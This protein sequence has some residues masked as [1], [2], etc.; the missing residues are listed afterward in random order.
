MGQDQLLNMEITPDT[1]ETERPIPAPQAGSAPV[2]FPAPLEAVPD[3]PMD[4]LARCLLPDADRGR[5][6][7]SLRQAPHFAGLPLPRKGDAGRLRLVII[8]EEQYYARQAAQHLCAIEKAAREAQSRESDPDDWVLF[9]ALSSDGDGSPASGPENQMEGA[10]AVVS[11][12]LLDPELDTGDALPGVPPHAAQQKLDLA[13]LKAEGVL[14]RAPRGPALSAAVA[15]QLGSAADSTSFWLCRPARS[16][17][18]WWRSFASATASRCAGWA[19]PTGNI[20]RGPSGR[21]PTA[22]A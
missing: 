11:P 4:R 7:R 10:L 20:R 16:T 3:Q 18:I 8:A 5:L 19:S 6:T 1:R 17:T 21:R 9:E 2:C 13:A 14:I 22:W 15:E 12:L